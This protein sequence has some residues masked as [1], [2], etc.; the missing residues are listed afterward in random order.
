VSQPQAGRFITAKLW[1]Y[2]AGQ[3]PSPELNERLGGTLSGER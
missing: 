1:N 2:F 3:M